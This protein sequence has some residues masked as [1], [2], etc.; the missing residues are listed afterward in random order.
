MLSRP[1]QPWVCVDSIH[2]R[3]IHR[4]VQTVPGEMTHLRD[5][6]EQTDTAL[7]VC[8]LDSHAVHPPLCSNGEPADTGLVIF[9][10][11]CFGPQT[12]VR[13]KFS[14]K[15]LQSTTVVVEVGRAVVRCGFAGE[16]A[17]RFTYPNTW[18]LPPTASRD[19]RISSSPLSFYC[20]KHGLGT[21]WGCTCLQRVLICKS[22]FF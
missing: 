8:R 10:C 17:P 13:S 11:V 2:T 3:F 12:P 14:Q 15:M 6:A 1:T 19:V 20:C 21:E 16:S 9:V 7:G 5:V 22:L 18:Y 4:S